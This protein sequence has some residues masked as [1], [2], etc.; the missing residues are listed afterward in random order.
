MHNSGRQSLLPYCW[1]KYMPH[2]L[3][4]LFPSFPTLY[5]PP[6]DYK[7]TLPRLPPTNT[8]HQ[9]L[10]LLPI[11]IKKIYPKISHDETYSRTG[12]NGQPIYSHQNKK[13]HAYYCSCCSTFLSSLAKRSSLLRYFLDRHWLFKTSDLRGGM[14]LVRF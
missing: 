12:H 6:A 8:F 5:F 13:Q 10:A 7:Q 9:Q 3:S 2:R 14:A 1:Y 4:S 11:Q